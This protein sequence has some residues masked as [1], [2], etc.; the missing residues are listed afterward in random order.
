MILKTVLITTNVYYNLSNIFSHKHQDTTP[1]SKSPIPP[2][3][4]DFKVTTEL[5][6]FIREAEQ[7]LDTLV[8]LHFFTML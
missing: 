1:G 7:N 6:P 2:K 8:F 4:L 5:Q 3:Y